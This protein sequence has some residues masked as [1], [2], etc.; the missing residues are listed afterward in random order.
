MALN[1]HLHYLN[2][3]PSRPRRNAVTF[4]YTAVQLVAALPDLGLKGR[5][6]RVDGMLPLL[7]RLDWSSPDVIYEHARQFGTDVLEA[8]ITWRALQKEE[9]AQKQSREQAHR[10]QP[11][12]GA[13]PFWDA[14][15]ADRWQRGRPTRADIEDLLQRLGENDFTPWFEIDRKQLDDFLEGLVRNADT[16]TDAAEDYRLIV[17]KFLL[18]YVFDDRRRLRLLLTDFANPY[19]RARIEAMS[20]YTGERPGLIACDVCGRWFVP[21]RAGRPSRRCPG[22]DCQ[23]EAERRYQQSPER[24]EYRRLSMRLHRAQIRGD[25]DATSEAER[26]L[27]ELKARRKQ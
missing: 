27:A 5:T 16:A 14:R 17:Q 15:A 8:V 3:K 4:P 21:V 19:D 12:R 25:A 2:Q 24:R 20:A 26:Q 13:P 11:D 9:S 7:Q 10:V 23:G 18:R 1:F 6:G 22:F